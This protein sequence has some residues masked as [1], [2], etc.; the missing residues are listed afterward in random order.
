[1]RFYDDGLLL[2]ADLCFDRFCC[3]LRCERRQDLGRELMP[4]LDSVV[5]RVDKI[6][7]SGTRCYLSFD[8]RGGGGLCLRVRRSVEEVYRSLLFH[9]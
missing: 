2:V 8:V 7:D 6:A 4:S 5:A 1:M 9:Y 3:I